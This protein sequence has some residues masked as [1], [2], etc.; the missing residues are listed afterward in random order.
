MMA[1]A[2]RELLMNAVEWGGGLDPER[3]VRVSCLRT[4]RMLLYRIADPGPG[5]RFE[6]LA[7]AAVGHAPDDR[8]AHMAVREAMGLRPGGFGLLTVQALADELLFNEK[9]NEVVLVKY[10]P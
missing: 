4:R 7:H 2:F 10:L 1:H 9:Q 5:F 3:R 8:T 6:G